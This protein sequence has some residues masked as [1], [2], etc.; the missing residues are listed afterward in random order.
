MTIR[1]K[2]IGVAI[3]ILGL[4]IE[5]EGEVPQGVFLFA[6]NHRSFSDPVVALYFIYAYPLAKAEV[7]KYPLV[8][9]G[10]RMT[11]ILFVKRESLSSRASARYAIRDTLVAGHNV[12]IYPEG[13]TT[14]QQRSEPF[15]SGSFEEA[16]KLKISTV[17][18]A[19][20]YEDASDH[21]KDTTIW[22]HFL[23]QFGKRS[24]RCKIGFGPIISEEDPV[25]LKKRTQDWIDNQLVAYRQAFEVL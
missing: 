5:C 16:A 24:C 4:R 19:I 12:L 13:T 21:W 17:P 10:A 1:Q 23:S 14:D 22:H 20:E 11:G 8:G 9:F 18:I 15:K 6:S 2:W 3:Y 7:S 25:L